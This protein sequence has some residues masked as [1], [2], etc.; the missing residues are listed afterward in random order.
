MGLHQFEK[1]NQYNFLHKNFVGLD[2][3]FWFNTLILKCNCSPV[4]LVD[5]NRLGEVLQKRKLFE[6]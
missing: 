2:I 4:M 1:K 3:S 5:I 6:N